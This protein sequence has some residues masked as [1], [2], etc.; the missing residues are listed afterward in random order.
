MSFLLRR[1]ALAIS[2]AA[3][4]SLA[5]ACTEDDI[6]TDLA[7]LSDLEYGCVVSAACGIQARARVSNC[8]D[9]Y[10][11][12]LVGLGLGPIYKQIY[13]CVRAAGTDCA[14]VQRC[15]GQTGNCSQSTFKAYCEGNTAYTCD[16]LDGKVYQLQCST[17]GLNCTPKPTEPFAAECHCDKSYKVCHGDFA[18][19]CPTGQPEVS[20]CAALGGKC[21][22]GACTTEKPE[23]CDASQTPARCEGSVAIR[24]NQSGELERDDCSKHPIYKRCKAGSCHRSGDECGD[25]FNRCTAAGD[26]EACI[27]GKWKTFKCSELGLGDCREAFYGANCARYN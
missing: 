23:Q 17:A 26:L 24:C 20:N 16:L 25:D 9:Y 27:D 8:I 1:S 7:S 13:T 22:D 2:L 10:Y 12:V 15:Y 11:D 18:V 19:S 14:A 21:Q 4:V 3:I 5:S 6:S